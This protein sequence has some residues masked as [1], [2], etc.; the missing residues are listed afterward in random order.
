[1]HI[2]QIIALTTFTMSNVLSTL[3]ALECRQLVKQMT[4]MNFIRLTH[5][6][7]LKS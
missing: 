1:V 5:A 2:D 7:T 3:L 6:F 4:G